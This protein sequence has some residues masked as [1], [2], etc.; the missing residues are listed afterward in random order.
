MTG[1]LKVDTIQKNNGTTPTAADLGLNVT[2]SVIQVVQ[3]VKTDTFTVQNRGVWHNV[4]GLSVS[5]TPRSSTSKFLVTV[6]I[7]LGKT[8][9]SAYYNLA[10]VLNGST[11]YLAVG[12]SSSNRFSATGCASPQDGY[13][14]SLHIDVVSTTYLDSPNTTAQLIY[15]AV[16]MSQ[17]DA[18]GRYVT[19][20][21]SAQDRDGNG[22]YDPRVSSQITVQE[23]A[24]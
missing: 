23:I 12:D 2:G 9:F 15:K 16:V 21:R 1:I 13:N 19:V 8:D 14:S 18:S 11:S 5:I 7:A 24:G 10:R 22:Y 6:N 17:D 4:P 3:S 20:N